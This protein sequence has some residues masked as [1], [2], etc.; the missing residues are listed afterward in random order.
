[1]VLSLA[2]AA[3]C[4]LNE[5]SLCNILTHWG[6]VMIDQMNATNRIVKL[7]GKKI[8]SSLSMFFWGVG[9]HMGPLFVS[10]F[11]LSQQLWY[12]MTIFYSIY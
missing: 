3:I 4:S 11:F 9:A 12:I 7:T 2:V 5:T 1:M 8:L 10:L 6:A